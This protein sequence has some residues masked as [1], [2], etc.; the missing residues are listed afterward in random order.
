VGTEG[1]A[2]EREKGEKRG[3]TGRKR[4][5]RVPLRTHTP[6]TLLIHPSE[7]GGKE[8]KRGKREN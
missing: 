7:G 8:K 6:I 2:E 4:K 5:V 3:R 1:T